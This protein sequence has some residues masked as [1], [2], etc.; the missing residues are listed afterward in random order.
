MTPLLQF[1]NIT[2]KHPSLERPILQNIHYTVQK[3]DCVVVLGANG[4]GKSSL[5]KLLDGRYRTNAGKIILKN[6]NILALSARARAH[7]IHTLTQNAADNLFFNL[8]I[9]ENYQLIQKRNK[10]D[11]ID[12]LGDYLRSFNA[13]LATKLDVLVARLSGGEQQALALALAVL[14]PPEILLL[15]EHTSAL[16]PKTAEHLMA[17]TARI[18][19]ERHITA[20]LTTHNVSHALA[21]GDRILALKE[22]I[23]HNYIER[24]DKKN[25]TT[26]ML[27]AQCY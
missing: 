18:I 1:E 22:G 3:G 25:L 10:A 14:Y 24:D 6:K 21:Y 19:H 16:D 13:N 7:C 17:L 12:S 8:T 23:V 15:D 20:L 26:E 9:F 27:M 5:L 4:S 11:K 2:L